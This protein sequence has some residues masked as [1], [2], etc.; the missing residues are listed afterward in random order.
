MG[1][2]VLKE[3]AGVPGAGVEGV[4][5]GRIRDTSRGSYSFAFGKNS[6]RWRLSISRS[7]FLLIHF[8]AMRLGESNH[9]FN[10]S[11]HR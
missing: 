6:F 1:A 4:G 8:L 11:F 2:G 10:T 9:P 5:I 3:D 7:H